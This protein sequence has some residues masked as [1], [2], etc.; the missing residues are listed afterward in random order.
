MKRHV[1]SYCVY[2]GSRFPNIFFSRAKSVIAHCKSRV[3][4]RRHFV[5]YH[6]TNSEEIIAA[7][8]NLLDSKSDLIQQRR[9]CSPSN[10]F[11]RNHGAKMGCAAAR[12]LAVIIAESQIRHSCVS[13]RLAQIRDN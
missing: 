3:R 11:A 8:A 6:V 5:R 4:R 7:I 1:F 13:S 2:S 9:R 10:S 12:E